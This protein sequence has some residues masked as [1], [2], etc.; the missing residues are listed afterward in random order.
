MPLPS[1]IMPL[2]TPSAISIARQIVA[3]NVS[4]VVLAADNS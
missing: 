3:L 4:V 1:S 2:A